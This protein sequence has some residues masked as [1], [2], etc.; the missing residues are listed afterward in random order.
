[1]QVH[2]SHNSCSTTSLIKLTHNFDKEDKFLKSEDKNCNIE[3]KQTHLK[4]GHEEA[5]W[6]LMM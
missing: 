4:N 5:Q 2:N 6:I 1:M 3:I